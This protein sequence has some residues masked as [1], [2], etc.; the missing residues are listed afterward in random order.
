MLSQRIVRAWDLTSAE[1]FWIPVIQKL[2]KA[3]DGKENVWKTAELALLYLAPGSVVKSLASP[4]GSYRATETAFHS[5]DESACLAARQL[6]AF[7]NYMCTAE[8]FGVI[9]RL[10]EAPEPNETRLKSTIRSQFLEKWT[11]TVKRTVN[12]HTR[13]D[14]VLSSTQLLLPMRGCVFPSDAWMRLLEAAAEA[15]RNSPHLRVRFAD[16]VKMFLRSAVK[17]MR[18]EEVSAE[19]R[20]PDLHL[21]RHSVQGRRGAEASDP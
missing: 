17:H 3:R 8:G 5:Y 11:T 21:P 15:V 13:G 19:D 4:G 1:H 6:H 2:S 7:L 18:A 14:S 9:A 16:Q 10:T 20:I 12:L